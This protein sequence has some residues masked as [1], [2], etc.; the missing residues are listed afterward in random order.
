MLLPAS[1]R[2]DDLGPG[3]AQLL[4]AQYQDTRRDCGDS[5]KPAFMCSGVMLRAT[6]PST[7]Y[8]FY[9][10]SPA[11]LENGGVS[12]SYLRKD[13]KFAS[14]YAKR[15][16]GFIFDTATF[17]EG[18][19]RKPLKVLCA[20]PID[21]ASLRRANS[22]CGDY[23]L[24]SVAETF[25]D[26]M[27]VTTAQQWFKL[28]RSNAMYPQGAQCAFDIRDSNP[29]RAEA[30]YQSLT[31]QALLPGIGTFNGNDSQENE[32]ILAPW[33]V[34]PSYTLPVLAVFYTNQSGVAAARLHQIHWYQAKREV[35]PAVRLTMPTSPA[36]DANFSYEGHQQAIYPIVGSDRCA[37]YVQSA[38]W[39]KRFDSGF[40]RDIMALEVV[41]TECGRK[42]L[43]D[44]TN[45]FLNE[46]V[47]K[48]YLD[49]EWANNPDNQINNINSM[50][51]QLVCYMTIARSKASWFIEPSR[52]YTTHERSVAAR[53]NN[54]VP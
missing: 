50:R 28:Y 19:N 40:R 2:A 16:S 13:S 44:Q 23:E 47:A 24:T 51:R 35:L 10:I 3:T 42:I 31:A 8:T 21:G 54:T 52:P 30:F 53:C 39:H 34:D 25:C 29:R 32:I 38:R 11:S 15:T 17:Y 22:G 9:S 45:N 20:F 14:F 37:Q 26:R 6:L 7:A 33:S 48:H 41:P 43:S 49:P 4:N 12:A 27:G 36:A 18:A 1:A 46:L 5:S